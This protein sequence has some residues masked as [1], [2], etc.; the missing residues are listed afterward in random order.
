[1]KFNQELKSTKLIYLKAFL[2]LLILVIACT[3]IL[4]ETQNFYIAILLLLI[5]WSS[6]RLYYFMF[7]VIE[8]YID[9]Q[10]KFSGIGS[11]LKYWLSRR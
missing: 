4:L 5:I 2:F 1:M 3:F 9:P 10:Y 6:A 11:F 7:Y 8:K